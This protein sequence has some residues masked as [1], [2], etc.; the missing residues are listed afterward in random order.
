MPSMELHALAK[1][2]AKPSNAHVKRTMSSVIKNVIK[3]VH[4]VKIKDINSIYIYWL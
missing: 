2:L 1:V 3:T 4:V